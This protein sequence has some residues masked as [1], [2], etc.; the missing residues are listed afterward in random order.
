LFCANSK[1]GLLAQRLFTS[2]CGFVVAA[3]FVAGGADVVQGFGIV[4]A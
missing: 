3:E 1:S 4:A 2:R